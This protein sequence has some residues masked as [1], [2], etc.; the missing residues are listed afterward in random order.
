MKNIQSL[1]I[2]IILNL[3]ITVS[4]TSQVNLNL[5]G[6]L[7]YPGLSTAGV[8]HYVDT[9]GNEYALVGA[10]DRVS[11]V[12]VTNPASPTEVFSV[13]ALPNQSRLVKVAVA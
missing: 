6:T 1:W 12:D 9:L 3:G 8:W 7:Q 2:A 11:I 10:A 4:A 5:L 13:P